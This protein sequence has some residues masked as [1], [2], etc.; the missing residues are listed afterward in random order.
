M[1][2]IIYFTCNDGYSNNFTVYNED[3]RNIKILDMLISKE[4][5]RISYCPI[6]EGEFHGTREDVLI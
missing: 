4:F 2:Y 3:D 1:K 6:F 5:K